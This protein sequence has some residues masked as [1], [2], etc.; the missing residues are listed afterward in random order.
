MCECSEA[1]VGGQLLRGAKL[2]DAERR[3]VESVTRAG[4][5]TAV[6]ARAHSFTTCVRLV[7]CLSLVCDGIGGVGPLA[8]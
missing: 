5:R 7:S 6:D 2:Q 1:R 4:T 8:R 3:R